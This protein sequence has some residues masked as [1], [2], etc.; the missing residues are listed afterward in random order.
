MQLEL[1]PGK[2]RK[3]A[4]KLVLAELK[5]LADEPV[6]DDELNRVRQGIVAG[7]VFDRESVHGMADNLSQ[8]LTN[9]DLTWLKTLLPRMAAVTP[10][11]IQRVAK[12]YLDPQKRVV[13]WSV[14]KERRRN[15][16][17]PRRLK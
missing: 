6:P 12:K 9:N 1:L 3:H 14:P 17:A 7:A 8:G 2:D 15:R 5:R 16:P 13:V 10:A 4:E 11:D